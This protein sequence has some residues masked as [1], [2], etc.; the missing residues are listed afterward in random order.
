MKTYIDI[1][2][3]QDCYTGRALLHI[4]GTHPLGSMFDQMFP[5]IYHGGTHGMSFRADHQDVLAWLD[6]L[7]EE[8]PRTRNSMM[9]VKKEIMRKVRDN[10]VNTRGEISVIAHKLE[11][12]QACQFGSEVVP[13]FKT[14]Q[15]WE[16]WGGYKSVT[17]V[18]D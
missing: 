5:S 18:K 1:T 2:A 3:P 6:L 7:I 9:I 16:R 15:E 4:S 12:R 10:L 17:S 13:I 8:F 11:I 14:E